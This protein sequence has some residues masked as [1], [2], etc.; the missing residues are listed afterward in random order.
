MGQKDLAQ[1]DYYNDKVRF[2][3]A[4]NGILFQGKEVIRPEEL[5]ETDADIV[6]RE[7]EGK[8]RKVIPDKVRKWKGVYIAVLSMENQSKVDYHMVFRA[9]KSEA[10]Y[11]ERQW[12]ERE[13]E[14]KRLGLLHEKAQLCW[15][16]KKE[17]FVPVITIVIYYGT[18]EKWD[19]ARCLYDMLEIDKELEPFVTNYK[20]NLFDYHDCKDFSVFKTENE[21]LFELL[22]CACDKKAMK[23]L[24]DKS[25]ERYSKVDR[26]IMRTMFDIIGIKYKVKEES[27][28]EGGDDMCKAIEEWAEEERTAGKIEGRREGKIEGRLEGTTEALRNIMD[29]LKITAIEAMDILKIAKEEQAE[30][31]ELIK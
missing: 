6:Y 10:A 16:G 30:Y 21:M 7:E 27:D 11:Y 9:M 15:S 3:D 20:L 17:R 23:K 18:D 5:E 24:L 1:N 8:L 19:G 29:S 22:S 31:L 13:Q 14:Y 26:N 25:R 2:A 4:C 12:K 28:E